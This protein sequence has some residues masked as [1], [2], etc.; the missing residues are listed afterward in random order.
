MAPASSAQPAD[1]LTVS[2]PS[3]TPVQGVV[4]VGLS[5]GYFRAEHIDLRVVMSGSSVVTTVVSGQADLGQ[6]G[7]PGPMLPAADGKETSIVYATSGGGAG[8]YFAAIPGVTQPAQCKKVVSTGVGTSTYAWAA[9]YKK[10]FGASYEIIPQSQQAASIALL[11]SGQADCSV[12][13]PSFFAPLLDSGKVH[14]IVNPTVASTLPKGYPAG[15]LEGATFG[16][17][18]TLQAKREVIVRYLRAQQKA[19]EDMMK[20]PDAQL[21][22][23]IVKQDGWDTVP[24]AEMAAQV[25]AVR[26]HISQGHGY[27]AASLWPAELD[28]LTSGGVTLKGGASDPVWSYVNRVDMSYYE[29]ALGKPKN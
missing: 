26:P 29:A 23:L 7:M 8:A 13:G 1:S 4:A 14:F 5:Q 27:I 16:L 9:Y 19:V 21:A 20:L 10:A 18:L 3:N 25:K 11:T 2:V 6:I 22:K 15:L 24:V 12:N 28:W 17:K